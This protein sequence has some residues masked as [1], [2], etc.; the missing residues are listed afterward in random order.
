MADTFMQKLGRLYRNPDKG[1]AFGV[2]A[3]MCEVLGWRLRLTRVII[4]LLA[5]FGGLFGVLAVLY[6]A[7]VILLPTIDEVEDSRPSPRAERAQ[8]RN[9]TLQQRFAEI[10]ERLDKVEDYLH[11]AEARLRRKFADLEG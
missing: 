7:A 2:V 1:W 6:L 10:G 5:V 3:G 8:R 11:S 4:I 9:A